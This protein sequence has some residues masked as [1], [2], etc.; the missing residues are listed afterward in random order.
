MRPLVVVHRSDV[1]LLRQCWGVVKAYGY[2][3]GGAQPLPFLAARESESSLWEASFVSS[4][5]RQGSV[6]IHVFHSSW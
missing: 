1:S 3:A 6:L 2:R 5:L 4:S